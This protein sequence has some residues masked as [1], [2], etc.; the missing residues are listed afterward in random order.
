MYRLAKLKSIGPRAAGLTLAVAC[1]VSCRQKRDFYW[2]L[3]IIL[4]KGRHFEF[5]TWHSLMETSNQQLPVVI[6]LLLP[7]NESQF[8]FS[9]HCGAFCLPCISLLT[10]AQLLQVVENYGEAEEHGLRPLAVSASKSDDISFGKRPL[11][12]VS[13]PTAPGQN[14][15]KLI[16][17]CKIFCNKLCIKLQW[18]KGPADGARD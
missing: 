6:D 10:M 12:P 1:A 14:L 16:Q 17:A 7:K 4:I 13:E 15:L 8:S 9:E 18:L 11:I 2:K 5:E 3:E